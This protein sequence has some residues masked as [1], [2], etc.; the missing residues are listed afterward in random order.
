MK[1]VK[2]EFNKDSS[3]CIAL[4]GSTGSIGTQ[5]LDVARRLGLR[6]CSLSAN[7]NIKKLE[8]QTREFRPAIVSVFSQEAARDFKVRVGDLDVQVVSGMDGLIEA[9]CAD[10]AHTVVTAV[11]GTIGLLPTLAAI[12]LGKRIALANKETLVCAGE[13][14]MNSAKEHGCEII[15]VDSEHSALF[16]C[17]CGE[18]PK[19]IKNLILTASGGPF[20]GMTHNALINATPE[21]ALR[22]PN[23]SMGKKISIDS[24]TLMNKGLEV[25][26][27]VHLFAINPDRIKVVIHP[28]SII[29]SMIEYTDNSVIAQMSE[30]DMRLPIQYAITYPQRCS[31]QISELDFSKYS[32]LTFESPDFET[33]PCLRLALQTAGISGTACAV[34]NGANEAAVDLF[35]QG[36]LGF[37]GIFESVQAALSH[38]GN[39]VNPSIDD[40]IEAD[41]AAKDFV[42]MQKN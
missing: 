34:L 37:Y 21:M 22:H 14:V 8:E 7:A 29:H 36:K 9:A 13:Y 19:D 11:V 17:L 2:Q 31:S 40:I 1:H 23:W 4:L 20:R 10:D 32:S 38:I 26:E 41:R 3:D 28:E 5:T 18:N 6:V 16:Q 27:A 39:V 25:I 42:Y 12:A 15:P 24:A 35:L 33:F 30:P